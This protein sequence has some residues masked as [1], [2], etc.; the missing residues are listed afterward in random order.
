MIEEGCGEVGVNMFVM[1]RF[2]TISPGH[3]NYSEHVR[4]DCPYDSESSIWET[5]EYLSKDYAIMPCV[6]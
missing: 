1:L 6:C 3:D 2:S 4:A 5:L